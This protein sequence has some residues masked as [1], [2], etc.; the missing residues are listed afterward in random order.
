MDP[1]PQK[2]FLAATGQKTVTEYIY[3]VANEY[4]GKIPDLLDETIIHE[5]ETLVREK[6]IALHPAKQR[7]DKLHDE[8]NQSGNKAPAT[9]FLLPW[10]PS[11]EDQ[12][13]Q[14]QKE[15]NNQHVLYGKML[16][17]IARRQDND[18]VLFEVSNAAFQYAVVHLTW[19]Q[20]SE[21]DAR[22]PLTIT[23]Q[24]WKELFEKRIIPDHDEWQKSDG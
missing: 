1:W 21:E 14:L 19:K 2:V 15:I 11:T 13:Q 4:R 16:K 24:D 20:N 23:Y 6:I 18:D 3:D 8:P 5:I 10:Q 22:Y 12:T 9:D 17:T 7:P